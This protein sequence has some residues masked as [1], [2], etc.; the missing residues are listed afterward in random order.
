ML[1]TFEH[2]DPLD[3]SAGDGIA[4]LTPNVCAYALIAFTCKVIIS[5]QLNLLV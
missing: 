5:T 1:C 4:L 2:V 3:H